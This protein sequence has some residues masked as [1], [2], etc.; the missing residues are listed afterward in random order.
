MFD[1][2]QEQAAKHFKVHTPLTAEQARLL[3]WLVGLSGETGEV[4]E[5]IKHHI[6]GEQ[7][8]DKM[9]LAKELGDILWYTAAMGTS[10]GIELSAIA[11]LNANKLDYRYGGSGYSVEASQNRHET[12]RKFQDTALYK[13][14]KAKILHEPAPLNVIFI[15]PD[16]VG[17]TTLSKEVAKRL[18]PEGFVYHKCNYEQ[19]NKPD[20]AIQLLEEQ[21]NIIYDRFYYPDEIL[22][23]RIHWDN[24]HPEGPSMDWNTPYWKSFNDVLNLLCNLNT[25]FI[26]MMA[27]EEVLCQRASAWVDDYVATNDL[28]KICVLYSK[29]RQ[30]MTGRPVVIFDVDSTDR[31]VDDMAWEVTAGI[32]RAQAAFSNLEDVHM[33]VTDAEK[34]Y[35]Q[36]KME[37]Q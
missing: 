9:A 16:G 6:F 25:V 18:E 33:F 31:S 4:S 22:Y 5:I 19:E 15:G 27:S 17:K 10:L 7:P 3:N 34:A 35:E 14:M 21:S 1:I 8:L 36:T 11:E 24:D 23:T 2:Y 29:W 32:H 37:L 28:H 13:A 26:F 20:L 30:Q 12:E